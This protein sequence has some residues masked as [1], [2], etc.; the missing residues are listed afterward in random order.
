[1]AVEVNLIPVIKKELK[2]NIT[3]EQ[4]EQVKQE[5]RE[6]WEEDIYQKNPPVNNNLLPEAEKEQL[7]KW[8]KGEMKDLWDFDDEKQHWIINKRNTF[9]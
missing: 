2:G 4:V 6:Y 8:K 3:D 9:K 5:L 7:E 1:M